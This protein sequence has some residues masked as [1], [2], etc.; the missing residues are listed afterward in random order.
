MAQESV[1]YLTNI[2]IGT[3]LACLMTHYWLQQGRSLLMRQWMIA[4]WIMTFADILFAGRPALPPW[5]GRIVPTLLVTVGQAALFIGAEWIGRVPRRWQLVA[6]VTALHAAGLV[7][8]LVWSP[9]SDWRMVF[10]GVI[11][12]GLSLGSARVLEAAPRFFWQPLVSPAKAFLMH[13]VFH[14]VRVILAVFFALR[15]WQEAS[16]ALQIVGDLE[17]SFFMV[18]LFVSILIATL[19]QRHEELMSAHAEVQALSGLL[20]ICSWCKKVRDDDG[21]WQQVEEYFA[22]RSQIQFTHGMCAECFREQKLRQ[23]N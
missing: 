9:H 18:A 11:W 13:G 6:V 2:I 14:C 23:K 5:L 16:D 7:A 19:Q 21:Y 17:V 20:P 22:S 12:A 3:I 8:F 15:D 1:I 10:N 4:A